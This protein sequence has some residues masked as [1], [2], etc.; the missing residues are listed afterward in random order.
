MTNE[1]Y[2]KQPEAIYVGYSSHDCESLF[3]CPICHKQ[4]GCYSEITDEEGHRG[5]PSCKTIL[6]GLE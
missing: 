3:E 6:R 4:F 2:L 5:C 1:E